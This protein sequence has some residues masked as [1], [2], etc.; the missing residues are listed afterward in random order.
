MTDDELPWEKGYLRSRV[1]TTNY[2]HLKR[3]R[4]KMISVEE[5]NLEKF[6]YVIEGR[7]FLLQ[8]LLIL[9]VTLK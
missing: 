9:F 2:K 7:I 4:K 1:K 8:S 3:K 5:E 6:T